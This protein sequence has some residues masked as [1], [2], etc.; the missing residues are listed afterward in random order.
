MR[1]IPRQVIIL[2]CLSIFNVSGATYVRI[3]LTSLTPLSARTCCQEFEVSA[4]G[5]SPHTVRSGQNWK[6]GNP[7]FVGLHLLIGLHLFIMLHMMTSSTS[8]IHERHVINLEM[9]R[10]TRRR[11]LS[12]VNTL[13][14]LSNQKKPPHQKKKKKSFPVNSCFSLFFFLFLLI[15]AFR[16]W[17]L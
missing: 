11:M 14:P 3:L 12:G 9:F 1:A 17:R 7:L 8:S 5:M 6:K 4:L 10:A 2:H 13:R 16:S 15:N